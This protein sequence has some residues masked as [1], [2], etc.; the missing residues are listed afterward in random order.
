M[1]NYQNPYMGGM[2]QMGQQ[3]PPMGGPQGPPPIGGGPQGPPPPRQGPQQQ[4]PGVGQQISPEMQNRLDNMPGFNTAPQFAMGGGASGAQR[5]GLQSN[6]DTIQ[7]QLMMAQ[8]NGAP[9]QV[10][11][12]LQMQL[13]QAQRAYQEAGMQA[14]YSQMQARP[15]PGLGSVGTRGRGGRP[16]PYDAQRQQSWQ[17]Q[18]QLL[19][20][21]WGMGGGG[22]PVGG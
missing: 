17:N 13:Q 2:P 19:M 5:S 3:G 6:I 18:L 16:S 1:P 22:G 15:Q 11:A 10:I 20:G 8:I 9:P 12:G 21:L 7:N 4:G 14:M